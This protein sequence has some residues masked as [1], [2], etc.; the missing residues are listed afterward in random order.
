MAY[1]VEHVESINLQPAQANDWGIPVYLLQVQCNLYGISR[2]IWDALRQLQ[3]AY[4]EE[5]DLDG[6]DMSSQGS[7]GL[8]NS[9]KH[10]FWGRGRGRVWRQEKRLL[11]AWSE[12]DSRFMYR[13]CWFLCW[14]TRFVY[15]PFQNATQLLSSWKVS[16][17][18]QDYVL[19]T[20]QLE[21][22]VQDVKSIGRSIA[23]YNDFHPHFMSLPAIA[24][25]YCPIPIQ[26]SLLFASSDTSLVSMLINI[27]LSPGVG[28][29]DNR[30]SWM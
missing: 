21:H 30:H 28:V 17:W 7:I 9:E 22:G 12:P 24:A 20:L 11:Y 4:N 1:A 2:E 6:S 16:R 19:P 29:Q 15:C 14:Q 26:V 10:R 5:L 27:L 13:D 23:S 25:S 3:D 18:T 8:N